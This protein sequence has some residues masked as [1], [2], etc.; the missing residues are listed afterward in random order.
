MG[1]PVGYPLGTKFSPPPPP[2][3]KPNFNYSNAKTLNS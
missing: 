3:Q 1:K 2:T